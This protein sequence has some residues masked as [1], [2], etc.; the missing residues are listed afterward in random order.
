M[1][2]SEEAQDAADAVDDADGTPLGGAD[3]RALAAD[4]S[5][6]DAALVTSDRAAADMCRRGG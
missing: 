2:D 1:A 3:V 5:A 6:H 4:W